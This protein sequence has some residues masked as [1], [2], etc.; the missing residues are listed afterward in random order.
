MEKD[1]NKFA[2][3]LK[4]KGEKPQ[5]FSLTFIVPGCDPEVIGVFQLQNRG[6]ETIQK[7]GLWIVNMTGPKGELV[8]PHH[9]LGQTVDITETAC[10]IPVYDG[11][12]W[13]YTLQQ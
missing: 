4:P 6:I 3:L 11:C 10:T 7:S 2:Q 9:V 1:A 13:V 12:A 8:L 5:S